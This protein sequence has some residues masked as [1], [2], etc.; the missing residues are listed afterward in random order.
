MPLGVILGSVGKVIGGKVAAKVGAKAAGKA[1]G[2]AGGKAAGKAGGKLA[3]MK[4]KAG[5]KLSELQE[6]VQGKMSDLGIDR[7]TVAAGM[8][9][10]SKVAAKGAAQLSAPT[11][12]QTQAQGARAKNARVLWNH[13]MGE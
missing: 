5:D 12:E 4:G 11:R 2:K 1:A 10:A 9:S 3:E 8:E 13:L 7:D 6:G